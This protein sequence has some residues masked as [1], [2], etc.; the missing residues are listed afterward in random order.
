MVGGAARADSAASCAPR[1]AG[2]AGVPRAG[3]FLRATMDGWLRIDGLTSGL[4]IAIDNV[5][6]Y[7]YMD[8][9]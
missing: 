5:L 3:G 9:D 4:R 8:I 2:G 6:W 7:M 1:F